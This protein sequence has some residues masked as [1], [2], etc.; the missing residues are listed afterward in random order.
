MTNEN[1]W[2]HEKKHYLDVGRI[3]KL[4]LKIMLKSHFKNPISLENL[5]INIKSQHGIY[6]VIRGREWTKIWNVAK[7]WYYLTF[8]LKIHNVKNLRLKF[9]SFEEPCIRENP[10]WIK[11]LLRLMLKKSPTWRSDHLSIIM[12]DPH[13]RTKMG[14][15]GWIYM[16]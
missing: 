7:I 1:S 16:S 13:K 10:T 5:K 6:M 15:S 8:W 11:R 12:K 14:G 4:I 9:G 2:S 3:S